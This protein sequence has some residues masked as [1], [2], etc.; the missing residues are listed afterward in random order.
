[1]SPGHSPQIA[2]HQYRRMARQSTQLHK[3]PHRST[4]QYSASPQLFVASRSEH[5]RGK[6][7]C[8]GQELLLWNEHVEGGGSE[9]RRGQG[10]GR[11]VKG[12]NQDFTI[13]ATRWRVQGHKQKGT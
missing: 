12:G 9:G 8:E 4:I 2:I 5:V 7:D 10:L 3:S 6:E 1:M 13:L 11:A